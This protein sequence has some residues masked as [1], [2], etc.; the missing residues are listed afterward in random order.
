MEMVTNLTKGFA[1]KLFAMI[2]QPV[3]EF[4]AAYKIP[5]LIALIT[6]CVVMSLEGYKIFKG[7][8]YIVASCGLGFIG[9]KYVAGFV[10]AKFGS[11][12]PAAPYGISYEALI[13]CILAVIGVLLVKFAY[14]FSIMLLGGAC[15]FAVGHF[16]IS[17]FMI[18]MFPTL[19]FL[20]TDSAKAIIG[21]VFAAMFGIAFILFFKHTF[22]LVTALG[23]MA[24]AGYLA[25]MVIMPESTMEQ[26]LIGLA[27]GLIVGIYSTIR[28]Y[29]EEERA[30]DIKFYT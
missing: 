30:T 28:Q 20:N 18:K 4:Y 10:L 8:L 11:M 12:L 14:K 15:G 19:T 23:G 24:T 25:C 26:K 21:L 27:L 6:L 7:L 29:R 16:V 2:P 17:S 22:I 3:L 1:E 9:Y 13:P 5:F